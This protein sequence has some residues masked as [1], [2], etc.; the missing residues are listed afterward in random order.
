MVNE[1]TNDWKKFLGKNIKI[2][3]QV[4]ERPFTYNGKVLEITDN[5]L[6]LNTNEHQDVYIQIE[7]IISVEI[8]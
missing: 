5:L 1:P 8:R 6:F 4:G 2:M 3:V 7:K